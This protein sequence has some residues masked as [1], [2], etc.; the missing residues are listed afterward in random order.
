MGIADWVL[1]VAIAGIALFCI[2]CYWCVRFLGFHCYVGRS[3]E[4]WESKQN[5]TEETL[6]PRASCGGDTV[7]RREYMALQ[8]RLEKLEQ[9]ADTMQRIGE[10]VWNTF[11]IS[12]WVKILNN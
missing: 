12:D 7:P 10:E 8:K 5:I 11:R 2:I 9:Q 1:P 4:R 3:S 6:L